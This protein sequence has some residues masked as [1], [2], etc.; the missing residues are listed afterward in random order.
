MFTNYIAPSPYGW[1]GVVTVL[2]F[3][4]A[5]QGTLMA[6]DYWLAYETSAKRAA[7]FNPSLFIEIYA[8]IA[9]V[10]FV[11][12]FLRIILVTVMG[13]KTTQIFFRQMLHS[14][15][16]APMT[17]FDTTPSGR[18]L[19]R[20]STDQTNVDIFIPFFMNVTVAMYI[21]L[22]SIIIITCQYTW[23]TA[24]FLIPLG[25]LNIWYRGYY[26][27]TSRELTAARFHHKS[28]CDSP[29]L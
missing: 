25:W 28:T 5:W 1:L 9:A 22:L 24:I 6:S 18:I 14:I 12:I 8:I 16:H 10:S 17:F 13:L 23:P 7:S 2:F 29:F 11:L 4:L 26:L 15:L 3:S 20:A 27:A 19:S 21:T